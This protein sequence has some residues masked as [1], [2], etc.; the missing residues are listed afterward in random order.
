M[1]NAGDKPLENS[2]KLVIQLDNYFKLKNVIS[3]KM[4]WG[5]ILGLNGRDWET[6]FISKTVTTIISD[7]HSKN[8]LNSAVP[9]N[10]PQEVLLQ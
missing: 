4:S 2:E 5:T 6:I 10:Y 1:S 9:F 8:N 3:I 7:M